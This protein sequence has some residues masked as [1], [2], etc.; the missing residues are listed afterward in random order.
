MRSSSK[1]SGDKIDRTVERI[2]ARIADLDPAVILEYVHDSIITTEKAGVVQAWDRSAE[3]MYG[4][5][6]SDA[7]G[8][9][10]GDLLSPVNQPEGI[11]SV[12]RQL[13][14]SEE[15]RG[16][17]LQVRRQDGSD[18]YVDLRVKLLRSADGTALGAVW[19]AN[20]VTERVRAQAALRNEHEFSQS[21]VETAQV[22]VLVLDTG[23]RVVQFNPYFAAMTGRSLE[24]TRGVDWFT[25]FLPERDQDRIRTIFEKAI[26][27]EQ[28]RGNVNAIVT[29]TGDERIIEWF[30]APL[31]DSAG[32][33]IG[34]LCTG[35]DITERT[36]LERE[37]LE[38]AAT[39]QRRIAQDLHDGIGQELAG[40][41]MLAET[42][43]TTLSREKAE[44]AGS[45]ERLAEGLQKVI[46]DVRN[47]SH[48]LTPVDVD[49]AGLMSA[50]EELTLSVSVPDR[51]NCHFESRT[52][53]LCSDTATA[54]HLYRI[55]QE[56][57]SNAIRHGHASEIF[58]EL[59]Q[60]DLGS[61][62]SIRDNGVGLDDSRQENTDGL[63]LRI[64]KY[65]AELIRGS[66][67]L[68]ELK[69]HGTM[70]KCAFLLQS[71]SRQIVSQHDNDQNQPDSP[72]R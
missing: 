14:K 28:T 61:L 32:N 20:D 72:G 23:G 5:L 67:E 35:R 58:V 69:P 64:M 41:N 56:A 50:L 18:L 12:I 37:V 29:A 39:E 40:F 10:L 24:E 4:Y 53:I 19:C 65:R 46:H 71:D 57:V 31:H 34:L 8:R 47:L 7:L 49:P 52:P 22:I 1:N 44:A 63:G 59:R 42:L 55:A 16:V 25:Q 48:G 54:T 66:L 6:A 26:R 60:D 9:P 62:L 38:A 15:F 30:D 33:L 17:G 36:E 2:S 13:S 43:S 21:L 70:V 3:T 11:Q 68:E 27:G 45:A 51:L